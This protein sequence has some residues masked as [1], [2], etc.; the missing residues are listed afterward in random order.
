MRL[1]LSIVFVSLLIPL[2]A[3]AQAPKQVEVIDE[4]LAVEVA[5]PLAVE[6]VNPAPACEPLRW[7]LVGYSEIRGGGNTFRVMEQNRVCAAEFPGRRACT[8]AEIL[9]TV[10]PIPTG[11]DFPGAWVRP[12]IQ[13]IALGDSM[14]VSGVVNA[15]QNFNCIATNNGLVMQSDESFA[16][17]S[18]SSVLPV[19][20]TRG[21]LAS[22][23]VNLT[24]C[25]LSDIA[26]NAASFSYQLLSS[27]RARE[28]GSSCSAW[29]R[30]ANAEGGISPND[31]V[32]S[33][34]VVVP[35]PSPKGLAC[36]DK[37][38]HD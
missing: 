3:G 38:G 33:Y 21:S 10:N 26:E 15:G 16:I 30:A 29:I 8:S 34:F 11:P 22:N 25:L 4:P 23:Q 32:R 31:G 19:A 37:F 7:Q 2:A 18:C 9:D 6:V 35:A 27:S 28:H 20:Q 14:D 17:A 12:V 13:L 24:E 36:R 5:E 1:L